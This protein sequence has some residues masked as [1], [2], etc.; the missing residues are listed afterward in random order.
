MFM[1]KTHLKFNQKMYRKRVFEMGKFF[2]MLNFDVRNLSSCRE[3]QINSNRSD[4][5]DSV[6]EIMFVKTLTGENIWNK[7]ERFSLEFFEHFYGFSEGFIERLSFWYV[8]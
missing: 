2:A 1:M 5:N 4:Y 3:F 7:N 8:N 6:G